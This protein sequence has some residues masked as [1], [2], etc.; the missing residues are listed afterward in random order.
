MRFARLVFSVAVGLLLG[1]L[2]SWAQQPPAFRSGVETVPI[3]ATVT[4][5]TGRLVPDL[6]RDEF[7]VYDNGVRQELTVFKSEIEPFSAILALDT[8]A[9][10]TA[11]IPLVQSAA[12]Q[13]VIRML[14][15]DRASVGFFN[16]RFTLSGQLTSNRDALVRYI[17]EQMQYGNE[18]RLWDT[19]DEALSRLHGVQGRRVVV[20][21]TDGD[22]SNSQR[23]DRNGLM[24]RAR[25]ES[26]MI[27]AIGLQSRYFNGQR[28]VTSLPGRDLRQVAEETGGGYFELRESA[29]LNTTFTRVVQELHSQYALGFSPAALDGQVHKLEVRVTR[30]GMRARARQS[31]LAARDGA[32]AAAG[33]SDPERSK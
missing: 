18:T 14:P 23:V 13:F 26:A 28:W 6:E 32:P 2:A 30:P 16:A 12:E 17:H 21:L 1:T 9:S 25:S 11:L 7:E 15:E 33:V 19:L 27:Y 22:D 4:D 24:D 10:M 20:A 31:Y 29:D 5:D 3:Y 8:S